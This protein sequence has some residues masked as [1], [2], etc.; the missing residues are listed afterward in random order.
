MPKTK[1]TGIATEHT[2]DSIRS[3]VEYSIQLDDREWEDFAENPQDGHVVL[4][5]LAIAINM[6]GWDESEVKNTFTL[7]ASDGDHYDEMM[8]A[9]NNFNTRELD[10]SIDKVQ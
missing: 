7:L 1:L 8:D 6:L 5:G 2:L 4:H 9:W 3:L 10:T